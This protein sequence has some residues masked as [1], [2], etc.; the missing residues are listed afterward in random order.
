MSCL[1]AFLGQGERGKGVYAWGRPHR[2]LIHF[3]LEVFFFLYLAKE[4]G[5]M[6]LLHFLENKSLSLH[7]K[8]FFFSLT[9]AFWPLVCWDL[10]SVLFKKSSLLTPTLVSSFLLFSRFLSLYFTPFPLFTSPSF[11]FPCFPSFLPVS[12]TLSSRRY[13]VEK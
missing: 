7:L 12:C 9:I 13:Y 6:L 2:V 10:V 3:I 4:E 11:P 1:T 5:E 8:W